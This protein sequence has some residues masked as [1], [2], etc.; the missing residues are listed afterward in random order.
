M[1]RHSIPARLSMLA[2]LSLAASAC[3]SWQPGD[4]SSPRFRRVIER[5]GL[6]GA[7]RQLAEKG[8]RAGVG[9]R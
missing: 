3:H 1:A 4:I 2:A 6:A 9:P 8:T 5:L 7:A